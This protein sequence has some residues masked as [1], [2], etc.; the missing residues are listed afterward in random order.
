MHQTRL[1]FTKFSEI[2]NGQE[3]G[4][5]SASIEEAINSGDISLFMDCP[6]DELKKITSN[7]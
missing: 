1:S 7:T 3:Q 4:R 6:V 5:R 2:T